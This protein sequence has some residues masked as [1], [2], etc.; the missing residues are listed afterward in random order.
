MTEDINRPAGDPS[1]L[2]QG[3]AVTPPPPSGVPVPPGAPAPV[4][5]GPAETRDHPSD[6]T[7][8]T[9]KQ[10]ASK[11]AGSAKE[12]ASKVADTAKQ[13]AAHVAETA[14]EE[15]RQTAAEAK[16]QAQDL[17]RQSRAELS[18]QAGSQQQ[19]LAGG[20]QAFSTEMSQMADGA[21]DPGVGA[22]VARWASGMA[23]DAG[24]WL[25]DRDP[26]SVLAEVKGYARR[27]PGTFMLIAAGLGLAAGRIARSLKDAGDDDPSDLPTA[28]GTAGTTAPGGY[29][30]SGGTAGT[31]GYPPV[32]ST[33]GTTG[34]PVTTP[35]SYAPPP[36]S[37]GTTPPQAGRG[38]DTAGLR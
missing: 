37:G 9:A 4:R 17:W 30:S 5:T 2:G 6:S 3:A 35:P 16:R 14:K 31:T 29:P 38:D 28:G 7:A 18:E 25:E 26:D 23:G 8:D 19:R 34:P 24:R 13:D 32:D 20:L 1:T 33:A 12:E 10:E 27:H 36:V 22:Q 15:A 21:E 11:V